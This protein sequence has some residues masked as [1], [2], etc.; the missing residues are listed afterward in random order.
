[1]KAVAVVGPK[2]SGKTTL[3]LELAKTF[4]ARGLTVSAAKFSHSGFD[5][6][7]TDTAKYAKVCDVVA[8]LSPTEAFVQWT[9]NRFLPD[10]LPLLN[11]DVLIVEGGK[12]LGFLPR[13]LCLRGDLSE[14][15]DWLSPELAIA[16]QG[17]QTLPGIPAPDTVAQLADLVLEKGFFLPGMDCGTCGRPDCRTLATEIVRGVVGPEAC[18]AMHN[19]IAVDINGA[20][21]GMKPFVEDIISAAIR[22]M[23]RTLKGYSPGKATITLDV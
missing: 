1:M 12:P 4:K 11:S 21:L 18:L 8:G 19:S 7:E 17:E 16:T 3:V 2:N 9:R 15:T 20:P 13:I 6:A 22:E 23:I 10:L 14:G 5:W